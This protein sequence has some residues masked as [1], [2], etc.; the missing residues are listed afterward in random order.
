MGVKVKFEKR[1]I[2]IPGVTQ[3]GYVAGVLAGLIDG[4]A[5]VNLRRPPPLE[6]ELEMVKQQD[7]A[8]ELRDKGHIVADG[9][10]TSLN[11]KIP[12]PVTVHEARMASQDYPYLK[13]H[14]APNCFVC[15]TNRADGDGLRIF[16]GPIAKR[17]FFAACWIPDASVANSV[18]HVR[19][20][21][22]W[23]AL[24][25]PSYF[26]F[27]PTGKLDSFLVRMRADLPAPISVNRE[28]VVM[29]WPISEDGRKRLA[30]VAIYDIESKL[31]AIGET[32][33]VIQNGI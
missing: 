17:D 15:G 20:E 4:A 19:A 12:E 1:F 5:V 28:H 33:W 27:L 14:P 31:C 6:R 2:G 11:L 30:G 13:S 8:V 7:G 10:P 18:G 26:A 9:G 22:V 29:A 32:L 25:C 16:P 3:G 23:A 21:I 24:D